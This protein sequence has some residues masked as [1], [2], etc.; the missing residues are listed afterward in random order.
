MTCK[1][2]NQCKFINGMKEKN[3]TIYSM[4]VSKYCGSNENSC[5]IFIVATKKTMEQVPQGLLPYNLKKAKEL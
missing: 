3:H 5:A 4:F 2:F 1:Y